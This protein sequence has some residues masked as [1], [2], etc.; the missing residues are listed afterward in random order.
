MG[1]LNKAAHVKVPS[2]AQ[3]ARLAI[4]V[5]AKATLKPKW[6]PTRQPKVSA[7]GI[8]LDHEQANTIRAD[9]LEI[10]RAVERVD[11]TTAEVQEVVHVVKGL[12]NTLHHCGLLLVTDVEMIGF[13]NMT[14]APDDSGDPLAP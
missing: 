8:Y 9:I 14:V 4:A 12:V 6:P 7:V 13:V 5:K 2:L 11:T 10:V 3:K 1:I